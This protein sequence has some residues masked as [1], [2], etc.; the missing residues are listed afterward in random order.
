MALMFFFGKE[1]AKKI[2]EEEESKVSGNDR[3]TIDYGNIVHNHLLAQAKKLRAAYITCEGW[4]SI[5]HDSDISG[6]CTPNQIFHFRIKSM[7]LYKLYK[8]A[9][10]YY[11]SIS[12][13]YNIAGL[14]IL[15]ANKTLDMYDDILDKE[16]GPT[17]IVTNPA[18]VLHWFRQ[19]RCDDCF[20][21]SR[22]QIKS[23][24]FLVISGWTTMLNLKLEFGF[25]LYSH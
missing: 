17:S 15:E 5:I 7:Y 12:D 16:T 24:A 3:L 1:R 14:S 10:K 8:F 25:K 11:D 19:Y 22:S 9:L 20:I 6:C 2:I 13:F 23:G 4:R 18:T 21:N